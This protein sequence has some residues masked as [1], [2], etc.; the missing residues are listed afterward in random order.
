MAKDKKYDVIIIG[1]GII[2]CSV[3]RK[4]SFY[5]LKVGVV[6]KNSYVCGG[7]SK[8]NGGV[9]HGGHNARE[10]TLKA[11]FNVMGNR[12]FSSLCKDLGV[13]F[14]RTGLLVIAIESHELEMLE[15]LE[16]RG[17]ANGVRGVSIIS[18]HELKKMEPN[19]SPRAICA[20]HVPT[21]G[22]VD[23]HR[24]VI[25]LAEHAAVNGVDFIFENDV[26]GL[27]VDGKK[28]VGLR[29]DKGQYQC[30][31]VI[32]CAGVESAGIA[33]M[34]GISRFKIIPRKGEYYILDKKYRDFI[35]RPC[36]PVPTPHGKGVAVFPTVNGNIIFGG[37]SVKIK[38]KYDTS[39]TREGYREVLGRARR[40][41]PD[42]EKKEI[43]TAF[44][45]IRSSV[46]GHDFI[47]DTGSMDG[48][49]NLIGIDSP[50]LSSA[51]A[52]TEHVFAKVDK[53]FGLVRQP[54]KKAKYSLKPL[55][56]ELGLKEKKEWLAKEERFG[57][58]ACRC[59]KI[60]EGDI[61]NAINSPIPATTLDAIKFKTKATTGRCQGGFGLTRIMGM[62]NRECGLDYADIRKNMPGSNIV[63]ERVR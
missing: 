51:P 9:I 22:I 14:K 31:V 17:K 41:I 2:G 25:A 8:A 55:F 34:A 28:V 11:K 52:I 61:V 38:D 50:G 12:M 4:L 26:Q 43:I 53:L 13:G 45:G 59:E 54:E 40:I 3:A 60:T 39:T 19:A 36:F 49:I 46:S 7:Q 57:R 6:E 32:N 15:K 47:I 58:I 35:R 56:R 30:S 24:L 62:L 21:A 1:A 20:L 23:V 16:E 44:S 42:I 29:T 48:L 10:G 27:I 63:T 5:N 33:K 37:N 18:K